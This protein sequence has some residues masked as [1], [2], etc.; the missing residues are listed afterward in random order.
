MGRFCMGDIDHKLWFGVQ[1]TYDADNF[2]V[3]GVDP[4][5]DED[6]DVSDGLDYTFEKEHLPLVIEGI[7]KCKKEL[8][9]YKKLLD[10]FFAERDSYNDEMVAKA[11][12]IPKNT[13]KELIVQ[14]ARLELGVKI[15]KSIKNKGQ[16]YF[17]AENG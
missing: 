1:A 4:E 8:G 6:G 16:C 14:Y 17:Y 5:P 9:A 12:K 10:K 11:L 3:R 2:G 13:A 7:E 15:K